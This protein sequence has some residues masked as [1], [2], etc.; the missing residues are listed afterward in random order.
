MDPFTAFCLGG[1]FG[2]AL[3]CLVIV[4]V[5]RENLFPPSE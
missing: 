3:T 5:Y 2:I 1:W 4:I